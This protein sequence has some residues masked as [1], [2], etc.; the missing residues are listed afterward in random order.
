MQVSSVDVDA[1]NRKV[2]MAVGA[3]DKMWSKRFQDI[4]ERFAA[5]RVV[6]YERGGYTACGRIGSNNAQYC[7]RDNT[8]YY[9]EVFV[10]GITRMAG[11]S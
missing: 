1:S 8:I 5:P 3:L 2:S 11:V 10:A 6:R 4:G 9:D 7:E